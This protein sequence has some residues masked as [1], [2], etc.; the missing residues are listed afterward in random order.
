MSNIKIENPWLLFIALGLIIAVVIGFFLLPKQKRSRPKNLISLGLHILISCTLALAFANIQFLTTSTNVE[1]YVVADCSD[2]EKENVDTLNELIQDVY[3]QA[4]EKNA[5][6]GVVA[7]AKGQETIAKAGDRFNTEKITELFEDNSSF[8]RSSSNIAS[9]LTYTNNLFSENVVRR[10]V[11]ISDGLETDDSAIDTIETLLSNDVHL[12]TV[13]LDK[14][15][16]NEV[17]ITGIEYTDHAFC[18]RTEEVKISVR[19]TRSTNCEVKLTCDGNLIDNSEGKKLISKGLNVITYTLPTS[20]AGEFDYEITLDPTSDTFVENNVTRFTQTVTDDFKVLYIGSSEDDKDVLNQIG[21]YNN[22]DQVDYYFV[23]RGDT[24]KIPYKTEDLIQYDE[25]VLS[26]FNVSSLDEDIDTDT[27][28]SIAKQFVNN[29]KAAVSVYGKSLLTFGD[30]YTGLNNSNYSYLS[31]YG[32]ILP[33][34]SHSSGGKAVIFLIDVSGSM[35]TDNRLEMAKKG[36]IAA[37]DTFSDE[38]M[39]GI[40]TFS[41]TTKIVKPLTSMRNKDELISAIRKMTTQGGTTM[42]PALKMCGKQLNA[43]SAEFKSI[44]TL[45]DGDPFDN[46]N[47][48]YKTCRSLAADNITCSFINISNKSGESL[49]KKMASYGNGNYY[50]VRTASQLVE[51]M[52]TSVSEEITKIAISQEDTSIVLRTEDDAVLANTEN[53]FPTIDGFNYCRIKSQATTVMTVTYVRTETDDDDN[54]TT[55]TYNVPLYAYWNYGKGTISSFTATLDSDTIASFRNST[56]GKQ[57]FKN[58]TTTSLPKRSTKNFLDL[59]YVNHGTTSVVKVNPNNG[60]YTG[61]VTIKV[62]APDESEATY[63]L[64]Y[65]GTDYSVTIPVSDTGKYNVEISYYETLADGSYESEPTATENQ[66]LYFDYSQ[67]YNFFDDTDNDLMFRLAKQANG[68]NTVNRV[69]YATTD[70]EL[71]YSSYFSTMMIFLLVSVVLFLVDIFVRKSDFIF[72]KKV[73]DVQA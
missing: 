49:L 40:V 13:T 59:S 42:D 6:V 24:S 41:D 60:D 10:M 21:I 61:K 29:L 26:D 15:P 67:E 39:V 45:S 23:D 5:K 44:I 54:E 63:D 19:S 71:Q 38:D 69:E 34:Q 7:Y 25:I 3:K 11:L 73:T 31:D 72:R 46:N 20:E 30:T 4:G 51:M 12:D 18:G 50:Y 8:D 16:K 37:L 22:S 70:A 9:A 2:S 62:T 48:L 64:L 14:S 65:D 47:T 43:S 35:S 55:I 17:A 53:N 32:D 58:V 1:V 57:F 56:D 68:S 52:V 36:A 27:T 28:P 33:V 66:P